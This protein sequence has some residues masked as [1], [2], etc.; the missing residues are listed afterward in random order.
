[1]LLIFG[2]LV[3][4]FFGALGDVDP[5][6]LSPSLDLIVRGDTNTNTITNTWVCNEWT[7]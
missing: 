4:S 7:T 5:G 1:M 6:E 2:L 3:T